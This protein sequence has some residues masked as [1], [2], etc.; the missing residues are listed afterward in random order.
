MH[1]GME[2]KR[3]RGFT[4]I[5]IMIVIMIIGMLLAVAVPSFLRA[6][7]VSRARACQSNLKNLV[8]AKER[9][10][11]DNNRGATDTPTMDQIALPGVYIR[12][13]PVCPSDGTYTLGALNVMPTC[14]IGGAATDPTAHLLP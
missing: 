11:M 13:V 12:S 7:D 6:R 8:G 3:K 9:W 2:R 1:G 14:S 4:L 10:A 5:E